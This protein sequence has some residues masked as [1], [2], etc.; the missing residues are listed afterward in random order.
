MV[1]NLTFDQSPLTVHN[2]Q[3]Q[4]GGAAA[5]RWQVGSRNGMDHNRINNVK[6]SLNDVGLV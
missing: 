4:C 1:D 5:W 3:V 2:R 6:L